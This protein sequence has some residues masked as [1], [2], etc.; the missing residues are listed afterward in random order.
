VRRR[1]DATAGCAVKEGPFVR[2]ERKKT[3]PAKK[4]L[5]IMVI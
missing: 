4:R 3:H 2:R 1:A 5:R